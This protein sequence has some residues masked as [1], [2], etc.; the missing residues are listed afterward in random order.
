MGMGAALVSVN[1]GVSR[2]AIKLA[3]RAE[4]ERRARRR[5]SFANVPNRNLL[6][7]PF[8]KPTRLRDAPPA[9]AWR[10]LGEPP[11]ADPLV[12]W[13]GGRGLITS[14]Y[15]LSLSLKNTQTRG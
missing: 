14:G 7:Q 8:L 13:C 3:R 4:R 6:A 12:P 11:D 2:R 1:D 5:F 15:R 10:I 9:T